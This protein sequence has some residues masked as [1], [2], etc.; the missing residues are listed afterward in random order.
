[1]REIKF[2]AW[3]KKKKRMI[4]VSL[5]DIKNR[6]IYSWIGEHEEGYFEDDFE[7][8]QY[9]GLKDK[10][11]VEIYE[12]DIIRRNDEYN[13][14][15]TW[16]EGEDSDS[17][18]TICVDNGNDFLLYPTDDSEVIGNIYENPELMTKMSK[19]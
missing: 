11:G 17:W 8:M 14:K 1:M 16:G 19:Q 9:T 15:V 10:N 7:L 5:L 18:V 13:E 6:C 3:N 2:R 4:D 12:G